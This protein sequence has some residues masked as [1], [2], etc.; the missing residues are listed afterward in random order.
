MFSISEFAG[1]LVL[2]AVGGYW[3]EAMR[4]KE[5]ACAAARRACQEHD[6]QFLDETVQLTR[7]RL[8]RDTAG[9]IAMFRQYRFEFTSDSAV[10]EHGELAMLGRRVIH[11][12]LGLYRVWEGAS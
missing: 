3:I 9:R 2:A 7:A 1:L 6:A 11:I 5:L 4:S 12:S 8:R 10:R